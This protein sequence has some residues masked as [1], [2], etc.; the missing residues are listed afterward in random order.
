[1]AGVPLHFCNDWWSMR[2]DAVTAFGFDLRLR[3]RR[4][5]GREEDWKRLGR[6]KRIGNFFRGKIDSNYKGPSW[7]LWVLKRNCWINIVVLH[8]FSPVSP[9]MPSCR[10]TYRGRKKSTKLNFPKP[11]GT[12]IKLEP[13]LPQKSHNCWISKKKSELISLHFHFNERYRTT[14]HH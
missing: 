11:Q 9:V 14:Y 5:G 8:A 10:R 3:R 13:H 1:M 7:L 4:E 12:K 2:Y 6:C